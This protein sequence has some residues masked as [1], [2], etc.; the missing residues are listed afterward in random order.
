MKAILPVAGAGARLRPL[1]YTLPKPLLPVAGKAILSFMI[2]RL[3][4]GGV[5]EFVFIIGFLGDKIQRYVEM[6]YPHLKATFIT[7]PKPIGSAHAIW[8]AKD[9]FSKEDE[10]IIAYGDAI[11]DMD[12]KQFIQ[13]KK[14]VLGVT[15]VSDPR[16]FGTVFTDEKGKALQLDEK[17][18]IPISNTAMVGI[19]KVKEITQ[20]IKSLDKIVKYQNETTKE[21]YLTDAL[22]DMI[23]R[24][25]HMKTFKVDQW[26]DC[27][28]T[29]ILLETN[30]T[31]LDREGYASE[32]LP[33]FYNSII[34]HPVSI[35]QNCDISNSIIG[36]HVTVGDNAS[37]HK[38]VISNS[39]IGNSAKLENTLLKKS[40]I[41]ND[42]FIRGGAH[43]L[44]IGDNTELD[45]G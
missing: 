26:F 25:V 1:T 35:G 16:Q 14:T 42:T 38:S 11:I 10:I 44:Y 40:V 33:P 15:K 8:L 24:G 9:T 6:T 31:F 30:A 22:N 23:Q 43:S 41:G 45:F 27:A 2:D 20:L 39:I 7:Q 17:P 4:K 32:D 29:E 12:F 37:I 21:L 3:Q 5:S 19:Y 36:P 28:K 13:Q 34:I 18:K